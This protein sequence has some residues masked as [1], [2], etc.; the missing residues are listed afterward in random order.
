MSENKKHFSLQKSYP[1]T[2][3]MFSRKAR[4]IQEIFSNAIFVLDTNSLLAPFVAGK[5]DI[6]KIRMTYEKLVREERLYVPRHVIREFLKNRTSRISDL[7]TNIDNYLSQ[8][9]SLKEFEYPILGEIDAYKKLK[10]SRETIKNNIKEYKSYLTELKEGIKNWNWS[11][12]VS[13]VYSNVFSESII[14]DV[15]KNEEELEKE[16]YYRIENNIPPGTR[17]KN[18][19]ENAI[20]DF[21][22][23][24]CITELGKLKSRDIIFVTNDEKNDWLVIGNKQSVSTRFELVDEFFRITKGNEFQ[25]MTFSTFLELQGVNTFAKFEH[26]SNNKGNNESIF[27]SNVE[28]DPSSSIYSLVICKKIF[29]DYLTHYDV[30]DENTL[31]MRTKELNNLI[32]KFKDTWRIEFALNEDWEFYYKHLTPIERLLTEINSLN[33][34]IEYEE[35]RMKRGSLDEQRRITSLIEQFIQEFEQFIDIQTPF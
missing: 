18:K 7:F 13:S 4:S 6:E 16:Y 11:D 1:D 22:I 33:K 14:I 8:I 3:V 20:G 10:E 32:S 25:C 19:E 9:P 21:I 17:D 35:Y 31:Y 26:T 27:L 2:S 28:T 30:T 15:N 23:W 24:N 12:P 34:V 5:E 29:N